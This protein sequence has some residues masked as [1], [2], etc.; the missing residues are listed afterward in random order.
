MQGL[1]VSQKIAEVKGCKNEM[2]STY[3]DVDSFSINLNDCRKAVK[4]CRWLFRGTKV[5]FRAHFVDLVNQNQF[6]SRTSR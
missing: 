6:A 1:T 2:C 5:L 3:R 4:R